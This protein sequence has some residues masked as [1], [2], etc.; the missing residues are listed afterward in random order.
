M[1]IEWPQ[2]DAKFKRL[3]SS[4]ATPIEELSEVEMQTRDALEETGMDQ[5]LLESHI[6]RGPRSHVIGAFRITQNK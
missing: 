6:E 4:K 3:P 1:G 5:N 2:A